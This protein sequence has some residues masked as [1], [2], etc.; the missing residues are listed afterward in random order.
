MSQDVCYESDLLE[1]GPADIEAC[2]GPFEDID[3]IDYFGDTL[4]LAACKIRNH[5]YVRY[6]LK[7]GANPDY[8]NDC[9]DTPLLELIDTAADDEEVSV[10]IIK[11][12]IDAGA[13]LEVRGYMD[14]TPFLKACSRKSLPVLK[15][16][17][18][19]GCNTR[20]VVSEYDQELDGNWFADCFH[21]D[22]ELKRYIKNVIENS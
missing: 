20:A 6:Y 9:G 16:L 17:V 21:L 12:L 18:E 5:E 3:K 4:L 7:K 15:L 10:P 8:R 1:L 13:N 2:Y 22:R 19:S 14:K 11:T